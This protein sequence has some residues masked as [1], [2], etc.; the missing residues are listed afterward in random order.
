MIHEAGVL[1]GD[2]H[3]GNILVTPRR[4]VFILDF[5]GCVLDASDDRRKAES[6]QM[7]DHLQHVVSALTDA[8]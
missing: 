1:H 8:S 4:Q 6:A 7:A 3:K 5:D 2:L